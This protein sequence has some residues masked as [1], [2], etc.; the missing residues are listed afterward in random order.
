[1]N[2]TD[3][4]LGDIL[5][6]YGVD[7]TPGLLVSIQAYTDLLL[8]WNS[9]ISLTSIENR[10]EIAKMHFGEAFFAKCAL[11]I[12]R[13][14]LVDVGSGA[15]FP[16]IP[17]KMLA[18]ALDLSLVESNA[19][20]A[21]FLSEVIRKLDLSRVEVL[22]VRMDDLPESMAGIDFITAR[23]VGDHRGLLK[24]AGRHLTVSGKLVLF[25]GSADAQDLSE[26]RD[27][28]WD[29]V[30]IPDSDR[31]VLLVGTPS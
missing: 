29:V 8:Q 27:W 7:V 1:M 31:R 2:S 22:N 12:D 11:S 15:G 9:K 16:G 14:W 13:G 5:A 17:I 20:K 24:W 23:A 30:P 4:Q 21:V 25:L 18:P 6:K 26:D 3:S 10:A 28:S 19:K